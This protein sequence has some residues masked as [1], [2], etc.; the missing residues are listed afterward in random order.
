MFGR[1]YPWGRF[2]SESLLIPAGGGTKEMLRRIVS[3]AM[4][5][6]NADPLPF[7]QRVFET[8]G[9]AKVAT[10]AT[11]AR[12]MGFLSASDRVVMNRGHL[13]AEAKRE[14]LSL[15]AAGYRPPT[16]GKIIYAG[17]E[18]MLAALRAARKHF[19]A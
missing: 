16:R 19:F 11:E 17:G 10:S 5:T 6:P 14:V 15:V 3:P 7:M 12:D 1:N 18:R 9:L 4:Q 8:I 2:L 13:I